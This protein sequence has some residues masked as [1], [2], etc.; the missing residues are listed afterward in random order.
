MSSITIHAQLILTTKKIE[1]QIQQEYQHGTKVTCLQG[2]LYILYTSGN[3][4]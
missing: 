3:Y 2:I 1:I 4:V